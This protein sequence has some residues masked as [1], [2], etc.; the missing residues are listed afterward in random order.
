MI[1]LQVRLSIFFRDIWHGILGILTEL[2]L[3]AFI[4]FAGFIVSVFWWGLFG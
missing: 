4:I 2:A 3:V 1:P